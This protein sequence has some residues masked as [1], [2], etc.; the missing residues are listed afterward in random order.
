MTGIGH[1]DSAVIYN[2]YENHTLSGAKQYFGAR[3]D[4]IPFWFAPG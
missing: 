2:C 3:N 1:V 4:N